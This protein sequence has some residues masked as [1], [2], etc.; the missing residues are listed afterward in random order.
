MQVKIHSMINPLEITPL[1]PGAQVQEL[2]FCACFPL[3]EPSYTSA[4]EFEVDMATDAVLLLGFLKSI[5]TSYKHERPKIPK[6]ILQL[7]QS[8]CGASAELPRN[9][10]AFCELHIASCK[11]MEHSGIVPLTFNP[12][13]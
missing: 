11:F 6:P 10:R 9:F 1:P 13:Y 5:C 3:K 4:E 12:S 8:F 7:P 2:A